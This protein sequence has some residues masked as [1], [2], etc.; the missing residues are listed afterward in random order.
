M[1]YY[2]KKHILFIHIPKTGGT[3]LENYLKNNDIQTLYIPVPRNNILPEKNLRNKSLQHQTYNTIYKYRK[4]LN[5]N[6]DNK[7]RIISIV[8]NP[9]HRIISDLFW[10]KLIKKNT[11]PEMVYNIIKSYIYKDC[12]DNHNIPQYKFIT[13]ENNELINN[14]KIFRTEELKKGLIEYGFINFNIHTNNIKINNNDKMKYL[15]RDSINLINNYYK[16]DFE[17]FN[18]KMI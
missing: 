4:L 15:N 11:S 5:I 14:I 1:P 6:F 9:Y 3:S 10:N 16:K 12:Y 13:D 17:L 7:L 8:R 18:Y 2:K